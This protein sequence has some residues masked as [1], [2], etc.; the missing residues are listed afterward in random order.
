MKVI[1][2]GSFDPIT[3]GHMDI[4]GRISELF[5]EVY[6]ALLNNNEKKTLFSLDERIDLIEDACKE[7]KN[8]NV[9]S[10]DGLLVDFA[11]SIDCRLIVRGI[12]QISDYEKEVQM[13]L[14]NKELNSELETFFLV[15]S[16]KFSFI[17]SSLIKEICSFNGDI[18]EFLPEL[19]YKKLKDKYN[20][21]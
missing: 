17:S 18:S 21:G 1:Y 19:A 14:M 3:L 13:A 8:I 2:P 12:R 20:K 11:K 4:I 7:I 5:D 9:V 10:F 15:S 16:A 6:V